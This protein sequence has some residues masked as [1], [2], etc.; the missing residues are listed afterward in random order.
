MGTRSTALALCLS[1]LV[2]W[3]AT[4][5][6]QDDP[7]AI[8]KSARKLLDEKWPGW[9]LAATDRGTTSCGP[10]A[11]TRSLAAGDFDGDGRADTAMAVTTSTTTRLV[12]ILNRL[13]DSVLYEVDVLQS[14][15]SWTVRKHGT[16]FR[17][18]GDVIDDFFA[19][20]TLVALGCDEQSTAYFWNGNGFRRAEI[21]TP[22]VD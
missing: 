5:A 19:A 10:A 21:E 16:K 7:P 12:V 8:Q 11:A 14:G 20:D 15:K 1:V 13:D 4:P 17:P 6:A 18:A 3:S 22:L 9:T 2:T